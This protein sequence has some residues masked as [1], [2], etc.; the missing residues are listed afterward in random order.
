MSRASAAWPA[1]DAAVSSVSPATGRAG[2]S[3]T[4]VRVPRISA[5]VAIGITAAV[6]IA[7]AIGV[8]LD[9][10]LAS[11]LRTDRAGVAK[12]TILVGLFV[13][14]AILDLGKDMQGF[15]E[16]LTSLLV[17]NDSIPY[18][19]QSRLLFVPTKLWVLILGA[20]VAL[21]FAAAL[22]AWRSGDSPRDRWLQ[23]LATRAAIAPIRSSTSASTSARFSRPSSAGRSA[24]NWAGITA[25]RLPA[26]G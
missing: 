23:R 6:Y 17:G 7:I 15:A 25:S 13:V 14:L 18:P 4:S 12:G 11:R 19:L 3:E 8:W 24:K 22:L 5:C 16:R 2:S 9:A 1:I 10:V 21:G 20:V 26:S